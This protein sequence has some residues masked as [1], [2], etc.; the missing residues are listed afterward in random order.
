[1]RQGM[2]DPAGFSRFVT[3]SLQGEKTLAFCPCLCYHAVMDPRSDAGESRYR[4][5]IG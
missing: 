5:G 2:A 4:Y 3:V 1:M